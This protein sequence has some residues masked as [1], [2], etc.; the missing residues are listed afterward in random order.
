MLG[1]QQR[2]L[3]AGEKSEE[4]GSREEMGGVGAGARGYRAS[5]ATVRTPCLTLREMGS[6]FKQI[7][8]YG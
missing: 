8:L 1:K 5:S 7:T 4:G 2:I 6:G 3:V